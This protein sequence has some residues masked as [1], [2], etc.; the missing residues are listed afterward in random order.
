MKIKHLITIL[1]LLPVTF[2]FG[3]YKSDVAVKIGINYVFAGKKSDFKSGL[4]FKTAL[5]FRS[6][7]Y[8]YVGPQ[9][10]V[11][12]LWQK[13]KKD[14][15]TFIEV[16]PL[17]EFDLMKLA[18]EKVIKP[19]SLKYQNSDLVFEFALGFNLDA[20]T[21]NKKIFNLTRFS[22]GI[23]AFSKELANGAIFL[24]LEENLLFKRPNIKSSL[25]LGLGGA[26]AL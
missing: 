25:G 22:I 15:L 19:K 5:T 2:V 14:N 12:K 4:D 20:N 9:F 24:N 6:S 11:S 10:T 23:D 1:F 7:D 26:A 3:Q 21:E 13:E 16:A 17:I 18:Y 8:L